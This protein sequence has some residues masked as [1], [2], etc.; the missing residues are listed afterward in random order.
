MRARGGTVP[1]IK[2]FFES[3]LSPGAEPAQRDPEHALQLATAAL[4]TEMM[5]MD[6]KCTATEQAMVAKAVQSTFNLTT[7]ETGELIRLA[8]Q[9]AHNATCYYEFTTLINKGF[10]RQQ[11]IRLVELMWLVAFA[12]E[13][14]DKHEEHLVRRIADL[15]HVSHRD[16]IA[17]KHRAQRGSTGGNN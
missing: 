11:K 6:D 8:E 9:E 3:F 13:E 2:Q 17:A 10:D 1:S 16:F 15:L 7:Q 5:R 12:D 14:I 4:L